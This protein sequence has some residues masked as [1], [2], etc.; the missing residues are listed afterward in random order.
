VPAVCPAG[1]VPE[2][3]VR[4]NSEMQRIAVLKIQS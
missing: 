4:R 1:S 2:T 3:T